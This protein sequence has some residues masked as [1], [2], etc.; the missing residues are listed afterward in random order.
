MDLY[1]NDDAFK[2]MQEA[3]AHQ[4]RASATPLVERAPSDDVWCR[5]VCQPG[6]TLF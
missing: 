1:P 6:P 4:V 2:A 3:H 5:G